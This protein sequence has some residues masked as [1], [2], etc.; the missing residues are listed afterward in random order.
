MD[1]KAGNKRHIKDFAPVLSGIPK[2]Q[3]NCLPG[4]SENWE[5]SHLP[6]LQ[7]GLYQPTQHP[8]HCV[9]YWYAC[10]TTTYEDAVASLRGQFARGRLLIRSLA[11][12]ALSTTAP[13]A[14]MAERRTLLPNHFHHVSLYWA[15]PQ[16]SGWHNGRDEVK[17]FDWVNSLLS[18]LTKPESVAAVGMNEVTLTDAAGDHLRH[19]G[20]KEVTIWLHSSSGTDA[21]CHWSPEDLTFY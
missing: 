12:C 7:R 13:S 11:E 17:R 1:K 8:E 4:L 6:C 21:K 9:C 20:S 5:N 16:Q 14:C 18:R 19:S 10:L 3:I 15:C 2:N